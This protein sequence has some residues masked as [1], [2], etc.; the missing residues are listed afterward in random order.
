MNNKRRLS[1]ASEEMGK[2]G[3]KKS[4]E[5]TFECERSECEE[6]EHVV[7]TERIKTLSKDST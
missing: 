5:D 3:E 2:P 4:Q 1:P 6:K 7:K